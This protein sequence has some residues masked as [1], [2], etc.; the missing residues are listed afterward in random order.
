[1]INKPIKQQFFNDIAHEFDT[2]VRQSIPLFDECINE[3]VRE[4]VRLHPKGIVLDICGSTGS[5]GRLLVNAGFRGNYVNI[6]GSPA[7]IEV[8][9][10]LNAQNELYNNH[11]TH[12]MGGYKANWIDP[13]GTYIPEINI[14]NLIHG[15]PGRKFDVIIEC[16]GFQFFTKERR[17]YFKDLAN[18]CTGLLFFI[19]KTQNIRRPDIWAD[20]ERLKDEL[21]KSKYFTPEQ[22]QAKRDNVLSDMGDYCR[23]TKELASDITTIR[24]SSA[25]RFYKAGN[26]EGYFLRM[27]GELYPHFS[28]ALT[29]NQYNSKL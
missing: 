27:S 2:H 10:K 12:I 21:H 13:D 16:L 26:F 8:G 1:M 25:H 17:K 29:L 4:I 7:M 3:V 6:D 19:E 18:N 23:D 28:K 20:N 5:L 22:L 14:A 9:R 11:I 15:M 24:A